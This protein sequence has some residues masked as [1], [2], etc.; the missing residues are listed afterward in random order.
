MKIK[1]IH[2]LVLCFISILTHGQNMNIGLLGQT[3]YTND[4]NDIWGYT[5][6]TTGKEY[7]LVGT[8]AGVSIVDISSATPQKK[9]FIQGPYSIWRDL[10]TWSHYTYVT[11]DNTFAWNTIPDHGILIIDMDS[12][13][14][15]NPRYKTMNPIIP[16]AGGG[17]D[18]LK[19]AHNLYIDENGFC[20][21]FGANISGGGA[22]IFDLNDDPWN[23]TY[24]GIFDNY[25]L[26]DGMVR[27]DTL[28]GSA[29]YAGLFTVV[30]VAVKDSTVLLATRATPNAFT[31]N[32]WISDNN[33]VLFTTDEVGAAYLTAYDVSDLSNIS[34]L[35]RIQSSIGVSVIPHNAHVYGQWVVTS[36]YTSG[37]QIVDAK[38]PDLLVEVGYYDTSPSFS[39]N[40]FYGNWGA[41]PYFA[42]EKIICSDIEEGLYVLDPEYIEASRV[43]V[44]V[45]DSLT[46]APLSNALVS[47][48]QASTISST[49]IDGLVNVGT[50]LNIQDSVNVAL[51]GYVS[52]DMT[53]QWNQGNFDTLRIPMINVNNIGAREWD[54]RAIKISPNP[55]SG[56]FNLNGIDLG[57]FQLLDQLGRI[58]E[59][60]DIVEGSVDLYSV[61]PTGPYILKVS[62]REGRTQ[63]PVFLLP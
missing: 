58:V 20:Y 21:L 25:Y 49:S 34:E 42:S 5:D 36:Y 9:Q 4:N 35:D 39:G 41:F 43:H 8:T 10:K 57:S 55:S 17:F 47:F 54:L 11:H 15:V 28:W 12:V 31:H 61:H 13:N 63:F 45:Y 62:T 7:A 50:P 19:T 59:M 24:V 40:G 14:Q 30:D 33:K 53:H 48:A 37:V 56:H 46:G 27:G 18:T 23:P 52:V 29:V 3:S 38:Y 2:L 60:G 32:T 51:M 6:S 22:L 16:L 44:V 1:Y 26:H